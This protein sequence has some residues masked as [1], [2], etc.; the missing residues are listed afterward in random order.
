MSAPGQTLRS[1]KLALVRRSYATTRKT[2]T[3]VVETSTDSPYA[4][5]SLATKPGA[6]RFSR[7]K[8][9]D[10][11]TRATKSTT[12]EPAMK[13]VARNLPRRNERFGRP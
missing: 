6:N 9:I 5:T 8:P 4:T 10:P 12:S 13:S 7:S 1:V 11:T 3:A 2:K